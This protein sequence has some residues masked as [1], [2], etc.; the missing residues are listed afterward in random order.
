MS[1][2]SQE[3]QKQLDRIVALGYP[4]VADMSAASFRA[5][6]LPL[7]RALDQSDLGTNILLVPTRELVSPESLISRTVL[8]VWL[9]LQQCRLE[10]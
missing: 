4:D 5:L 3:I 9:V 8:I 7:I 6:A 2:A 10:I 1:I